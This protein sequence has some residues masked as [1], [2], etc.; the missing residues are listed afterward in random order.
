MYGRF[1]IVFQLFNFEAKK[2][3]IFFRIYK[4]FLHHSKERLSA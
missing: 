4:L 1:D 3:H 2:Y